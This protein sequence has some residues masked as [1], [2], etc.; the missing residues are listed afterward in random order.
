MLPKSKWKKP[1][2]KREMFNVW[3]EINSDHHLVN[4]W[5]EIMN[6]A[7][8]VQDIPLPVRLIQLKYDKY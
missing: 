6:E 3:N 1:H 4:S 2:E 8:F 7:C 5:M